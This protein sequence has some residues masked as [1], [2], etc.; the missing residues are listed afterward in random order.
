MKV[1]WLTNVPLS[2][3]R[4][5]ISS[6]KIQMGGWIDGISSQLLKRKDIELLSIFPF[7]V[8]ECCSGII[9]NI[10][11][12]AYPNN[13][14]LNN[15]IEL[16]R[17]TVRDFNPD[18]IHIFGTE[19]RQSY[20]MMEASEDLDL[21]K[22]CVISIQGLC[23]FYSDVYYA[24]LPNKVINFWTLRDFLRHDNIRVQRSKYAKR[25]KYE[26]A[27]LKLAKNVIGRTDWDK[28]CAFQINPNINYYF[29]NE[30]L[31]DSF[32]EDKCREAF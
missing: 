18:I 24:G 21:V 27:A 25:G 20:A 28:A 9:D 5:N 29:C 22:K 31:R 16:F 30:T 6:S 7:G 10:Q 11:Y 17:K 19:F 8:K 26:I 15:E 23:S 1:L 13:Y 14:K 2:K 32:Y 4:A 3:V 12:L